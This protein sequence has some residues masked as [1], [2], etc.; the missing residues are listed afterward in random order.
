MESYQENG[1]LE[2]I[3][4][5]YA[6][7]N[8]AEKKV[9]KYILENPEDIIHFSITELAESSDVS[10]ATVSRLC[11]KLQYK[12]YQQLKINL[13]GAVL[14]PIQNIHQEIKE[15]DDMYIILQKVLHSNIA[16]FQKTVEINDS[17]ELEKATDLIVK[18]D[19]ILFFGM[20]GSGSLAHDAYHKFVRTGIRCVAHTDSHWQAM[21]ASMSKENDVVIA[22]SN[23]GSNKDLMESIEI[24]KKNKVKIILI[25]GNGKSPIAKLSDIV[26]VSYGKESMFKSEAMESR[27]TALML[28]D[29]LYI[30]TAM[31]MQEVTLSTLQ[32]IREGIAVKRF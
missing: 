27:M 15:N 26:L 13:A 8:D 19:Q 24:A 20:G 11:K 22:F 7:L 16:S 14:E 18:A 10:D 23:S 12:G 1:C 2:R 9:A 21:Y 29:C 32:K 17:K 4:E 6:D 30:R 25:T 28:V 3:R 31:K 5:A